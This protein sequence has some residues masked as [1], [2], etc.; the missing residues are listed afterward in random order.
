LSYGPRAKKAAAIDN[1]RQHLKHGMHANEIL[2][3]FCNSVYNKEQFKS[4][5]EGCILP[6]LKKRE[7]YRGITLPSIAGKVYISLLLNRIQPKIEKILRK[8]QN[9]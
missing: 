7:D 8:N 4:W 5:T 3:S 6:F 2:L 1:N 9:D